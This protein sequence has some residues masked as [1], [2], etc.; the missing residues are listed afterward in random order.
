MKE[1]GIVDSIRTTIGVHSLIPCWA[2]ASE[3]EIKLPLNPK[4]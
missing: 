3:P 1:I 4:L 2:A